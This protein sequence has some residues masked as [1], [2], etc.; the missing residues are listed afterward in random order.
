M[1]Q[2]ELRSLCV[3]SGASDRV[4]STF[5]EA[6]RRVGEL[7]AAAGLDLIYGGAS[8]GMMGVVADAALSAGGRV[9][10][11]IPRA[12]Q[13]LEIAHRGLTELHVVESMHARKALMADLSDAFVALPGGFGTLDELFEIVTWAQLKIHAKPIA[14]LDVANYYAGL[15]AFVD[16]GVATG[17]VRPEHRRLLIR[18]VAPDE[19]LD[20]LRRARSTSS[21]EREPIPR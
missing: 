7:V 14:L 1:V 19:L 12:L 6:A 10:G 13:D 8:V 3:F 9:I 21:F 5:R 4:D 18:V 15:C 2:P 20:A 11:V 16:H 17:F